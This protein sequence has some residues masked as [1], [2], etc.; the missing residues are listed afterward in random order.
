MLFSSVCFNASVFSG[1]LISDL[2]PPVT[3]RNEFRL[4][5]VNQTLVD[6]SDKLGP[7]LQVKGASRN[8]FSS[9][10]WL[11]EDEKSGEQ[12]MNC[13]AAATE[14]SQQLE[15]FPVCVAQI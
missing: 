12:D 5:F 3:L 11:K 2:F 14:I 8:E 15:K 9:E 10:R 7:L 4:N 13:A 6:L 1:N